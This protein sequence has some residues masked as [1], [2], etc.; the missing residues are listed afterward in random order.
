MSMADQARIRAIELKLV[1]LLNRLCAVEHAINE[2]PEPSE[3]KLCPKCGVKPAY[4]F[5]VLHCK[6]NVSE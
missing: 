6:G 5:H 2:P 3:R 4:H 1:E